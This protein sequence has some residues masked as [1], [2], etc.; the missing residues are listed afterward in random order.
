MRLNIRLRPLL[1]L[2]LLAA[3]VLS[4]IWY[5]ARKRAEWQEITRPLTQL[6]NATPVLAPVAPPAQAA[7]PQPAEEGFV[8]ARLE[9]DRARAAQEESLHGMAVD[10]GLPDD[11]RRSAATQLTALVRRRA[12]EAELEQ[13]LREKGFGDTLVTLDENAARVLVR[14]EAALTAHQLAQIAD[15]ARQVAGLRPWQLAVLTRP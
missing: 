3:V 4:L 14:S 8:L 2:A 12:M 10:Q 9:R 5:V 1:R 13:V 7:T 6:Q 11:S 15:A